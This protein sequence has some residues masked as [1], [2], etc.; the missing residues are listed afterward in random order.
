[1]LADLI[2]AELQS[3]ASADKRAVLMKFFKTAPGEYGE[4]DQFLGIAVPLIRNTAKAF[5]GADME[6][7]EV[8]MGS[9]WHE[10]RLCALFLL[11]GKFKKNAGERERIYQ[12]YLSK[13]R[14]INNWD[15]VDLSAP[16]IVG[17]YLI[18][19]PRNIL[20]DLAGDS[21]LWN[22]RIAVVSTLALIRNNEFT[23]TLN[24][25]GLLMNDKESLMHKAMGWMLREIGKRD[26]QALTSFLDKQAAFLPR[27]ALRYSLERF[28]EEQRKHYMGMKRALY[29]EAQSEK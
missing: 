15:L 24:L 18:D 4:G 1:M 27:T 14:F 8:L 22:R 19:K 11:I 23:D 16:Q 12:Y 28:P 20:Y 6:T 7:I 5:A 2:L 3:I 29:Q 17:K 21:L 25:I 26:K 13:T 9:Q 10:A